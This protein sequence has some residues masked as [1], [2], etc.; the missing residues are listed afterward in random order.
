[1]LAR[2]K[3]RFIHRHRYVDRGISVCERWAKFENFLADM[4]E[5]PPGATLDRINNDGGYEPGNC[6]WATPREQARNRSTSKLT[7]DE[8][9]TI[10]ARLAR[11]DCGNQMA[12]E[13]GVSK[14]MIYRIKWGRAWI[15][16]E[17]A[18][19]VA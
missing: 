15:D 13:Y 1:M 7:A 10:K 4:G 9:A 16:V 18:R 19:E 8:V 17:P 3:P 6:R 2:V 12:A 11:G 14:Q 5:P